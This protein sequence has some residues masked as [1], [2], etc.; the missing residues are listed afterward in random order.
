MTYEEHFDNALSKIMLVLEATNNDRL[1]KSIEKIFSD[2]DM[3]LKLD[4]IIKESK[5]TKIKISNI[6]K[7]TKTMSVQEKLDVF[8][9]IANKDIFLNA[10]NTKRYR[11]FRDKKNKIKSTECY[12]CGGKA[13]CMHHIVPLISGGTNRKGNL[14]PVCECCHKKIHTFMR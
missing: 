10:K 5:K 6:V 7:K 11:K 13:Y 2:F 9:E 4:G 12:I 14:I 1:K 3:W 8:K